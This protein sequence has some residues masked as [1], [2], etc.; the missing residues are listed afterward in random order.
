MKVSKY[1]FNADREGATLP[2]NLSK[3]LSSASD[4]KDLA[5]HLGVSPQAINQYKL[6]VS[7]P[8]TE[9]LIKIAEYYGISVDY[10]LDLTDVPNRDTSIQAVN[11]VTGLS[12]GAIVK[13]HELK[14]DPGLIDVVSA[15]IEDHNAGFF[16]SLLETI[17]SMVDSEAGKELLT[18]EICGKTLN[19]YKE[20]HLTAV[21]QA[22]LIENIPEVARIYKSLSGKGRE[23]NGE[24]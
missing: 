15:L 12:A 8:K 18:L 24:H 7:Y 4:V 22:K 16:L 21:F 10:L 13:L 5:K 20:N 23:N 2:S 6:G 1:G 11:E 19:L 9:N 14:A 3:L 17:Y